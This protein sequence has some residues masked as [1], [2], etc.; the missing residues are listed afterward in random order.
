MMLREHLMRLQHALRRDMR[1]VWLAVALSMAAVSHAWAQTAENVA[2]VI[3][4]ASAESRQIGEHYIKARDIPAANVIRIKTTTDETIQPAAYAVTIQAPIANALM[5]GGILDRVLYIVLT[6]GIPLR[7]LGT[8]GPDGTVASVDSELTLLYRRL[9]GRAVAARGKID[10]PY[11][12]GTRDITEARP[13]THRDHDIFLVSRLDAFTVEEAISLVT[14]AMEPSRD[15]RIVLDQRDALV[16]RTGEDWMGQAAENLTKQ[17]FG[18]RVTL[19][20]TPK[21]ARGISPV[22]GYFSWGSTDPQN[23]VRVVKM[24]FAPG[25]IAATFVSTDARTFKEPP[26][27]WLPTNVNDSSK[28][29][30]GSS[31]SLI[32]DLIREGATGVAGQVSEPYLES[33]IR[34]DVLFPAYLAGFNLIESFYLATPHLSWQT[35]VVGDPLCAP[36]QRRT[37]SRADIDGG[38]DPDTD[39]PA[40][41]AKRRVAQS[42]TEMPGAPDRAVRLVVHAE[43]SINKGDRAGARRFLEQASE[44]AP[45]QVRPH[46]LLAEL[47]VLAGEP[48]LAA[49][50]YRKIIAVEPGNMLALNNLAYD[51]AVRE[52]KPAE[53]LPLARKAQA[54][55]PREPT[56]L[57]TVGWIE[58]LL[59]NTAEAARLLVQAARAVPGNAEIRLHN[60]FALAAQGAR[61]S[62][63][64]ELAE[65][66]KL[67]AAFEK[68]PDVQELKAKLQ[69]GQN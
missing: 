52:K 64:T 20:T 48:A 21:P 42:A 41:F 50:R 54:L 7:V 28:F 3:N 29:F 6:K 68:R 63:E 67:N 25:A 31:Q 56:V 15:G 34:P 65:A 60:A 38:I 14:K 51:M 9:T 58:Y 45:T 53:A 69:A 46:V 18:G 32:G 5:R 49:D 40:F 59:G 61:A 47:Y 22:I 17:G 55:A 26:A 8:N 1:C 2:V 30:G 36:F 19:E 57:D 39:L 16:N 33:A 24:D 62:A 4:E 13:F 37:V 11:F 44:L 35:V 12:L 66:L 43:T 23:R 10:N 27:D